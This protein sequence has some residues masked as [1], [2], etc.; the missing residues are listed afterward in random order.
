M[1]RASNG[2]GLRRI[3]RVAGVL[4]NARIR[5][6]HVEIGKLDAAKKLLDHKIRRS[7]GPNSVNDSRNPEPSLTNGP[8][9]NK[10]RR[11]EVIRGGGCTVLCRWV[12]RD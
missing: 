2:C 1:L 8:A 12:L 10:S 7:F 11:M 9:W 6:R 3:S 5:S 4:V